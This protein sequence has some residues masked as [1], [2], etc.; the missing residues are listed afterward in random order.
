MAKTSIEYVTYSWSGWRG[1]Q[2]YHVGC[3]NCF[4][5]ELAKRNPTVLGKWGPNGTRV[6]AADKYW[7]EPLKWNTQA[8]FDSQMAGA[9]VRPRVLWDLSDP[10]EDWNGVMFDHQGEELGVMV[11]KGVG[12]SIDEPYDRPM[13]MLDVRRRAFSLI[14]QTPSLDWLLL[15][16]RPQNVLRML[17]FVEGSDLSVR[18]HNV[19]LGAS[20]SDQE[21]ADVLAPELLKHR[22]LCPVLWLSVEPLIG[23]IDLRRHLY[24]DYDRAALDPQMTGNESRAKL[25]WVVIGGESG[26]KARPCYVR[27]IKDIVD[28][29]EDAGVP[30]YVK[31]VGSNA[32]SDS[33]E[34]STAG[35]LELKHKK[36]G[37]KEEWPAEIRKK[38]L[39]HFE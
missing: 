30:C 39:P 6:V 8:V 12:L 26:P 25:D 16:K 36:G 21:T 22:Q 33:G 3:T 2:E 27:W 34:G 14:D 35:R 23:P 10:F 28:Q 11:S 29:C 32:W 15:T 13:I 4:A 18:R 7:K 20:V 1:C 37:K 31:Q 17:P 38:Q 5:R 19:W 24:S 9:P